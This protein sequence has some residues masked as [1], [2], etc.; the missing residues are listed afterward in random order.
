M[1]INNQNI[2]KL[3]IDSKVHLRSFMILSCLLVS[4]IAQGQH[5]PNILSN[6]LIKSENYLPDFSYA[7]Y[8]FSEVDIPFESNQCISVKLHPTLTDCPDLISV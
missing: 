4:L 2:L 6:K 8:H 3:E 5:V 1:K 7:G